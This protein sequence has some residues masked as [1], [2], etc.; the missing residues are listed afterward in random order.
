VTAALRAAVAGYLT[1]TDAQHAARRERSSV[2]AEVEARR[3]AEATLRA[4]PAST[5]PLADAAR[6]YLAALDAVRVSDHGP[7]AN[8]AHD[9]ALNVLRRA[10]GAGG[11]MG[12][13]DSWIAVEDAATRERVE[14]PPETLVQGEFWLITELRNAPRGAA[15]R[16]REGGADWP[17]VVLGPV[18][19]PAAAASKESR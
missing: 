1:A 9:L 15:V 19:A 8:A 12:S 3:A 16:V 4:A 10:F 18:A 14:L 13:R 5:G 17:G 7:L 2:V 11:A 6:V